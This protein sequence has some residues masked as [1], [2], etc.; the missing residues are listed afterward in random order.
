MTITLLRIALV[1]ALCATSAALRMPAHTAKVTRQASIASLGLGATLAIVAPMEADAAMY[2]MAAGATPDV[3]TALIASASSI[4]DEIMAD[5]QLFFA[6]AAFVG[7]AILPTV[8][9]KKVDMWAMKDAEDAE[10]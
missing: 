4:A 5:K 9:E 6:A 8:R 3:A 2:N 7:T 1:S 10:Q